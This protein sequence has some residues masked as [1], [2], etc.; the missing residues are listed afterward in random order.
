MY[1]IFLEPANDMVVLVEK[2]KTLRRAT[3]NTDDAG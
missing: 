3:R 1:I 2:L